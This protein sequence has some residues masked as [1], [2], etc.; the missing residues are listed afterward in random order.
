MKRGVKRKRRRKPDTKDRIRAV[1]VAAVLIGLSVAA[2]LVVS[3]FRSAGTETALTEETHPAPPP[4]APAPVAPAPVS[5]APAAAAPV[6][7]APAAPAPAAPPPAAPAPAAPVPKAPEAPRP[8]AAA[9]T[10][11]PS[12]PPGALVEKPQVSKGTLVFVID[13]A[14]NSLHDLEPFLK[15][16]MPLTIAVLPGLPYSAETARRIRS[17][18]KEV[19]LHQPM[20]AIG[21][22]NP[23]P[24]AIMS[25][26]GRDEIRA[27]I[28]RNLDEIWPVAGINNHEGSRITMDE[29]AMETVLALCRERGILF[30]D[31][32][33]TSETA[34]P[35][36]ARRLSMPIGER[37]VFVDNEKD[38]DS[39]LGYI[40]SG[41]Q[42]AEQKGSAI[43]IGHVGTAALAPL[44]SELFPDL[45][46]RGYSFSP[47]SKI[48]K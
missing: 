16:S 28:N 25:G 19:F 41:L 34:A 6:A 23:G 42:K 8:V 40:N 33:T 21:G 11:V 14:G 36:A 20:E 1:L 3:Y 4:A 5:S 17:A 24:G 44:L 48:I 35:K 47:A 32:R 13:D 37:D 10:A 26:M 27:V 9:E 31:S 12:R 15:L 43:M 38:R 22:R 18:G 2:S 30:L 45:G 46:S 7:S 29:E 39:M